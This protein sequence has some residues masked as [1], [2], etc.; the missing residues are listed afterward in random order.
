M[1]AARQSIGGLFIAHN[2]ARNQK[3]RKQESGKSNTIPSK[4]N[5]AQ[6]WEAAAKL[7]AAGSKIGEIIDTINA[8]VKTAIA[9]E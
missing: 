7:E 1:L 3:N 2:L 6:S 8:R 5:K 9:R 4:T